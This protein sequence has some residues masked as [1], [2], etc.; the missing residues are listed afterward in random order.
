M[1]ALGRWF[2]GLLARTYLL[3]KSVWGFAWHACNGVESLSVCVSDP[4]SV[5]QGF[6]TVLLSFY[7]KTRM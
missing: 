2:C 7:G 5:G 4:S 6:G 1:G 3:R